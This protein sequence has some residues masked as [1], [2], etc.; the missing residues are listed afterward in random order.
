MKKV[1]LPEKR[2]GTGGNGEPKAGEQIFVR[3]GTVTLVLPEVFDE[4]EKTISTST[5]K[6][7]RRFSVWYLGVC[8]CHRARLAQR[9][10]RVEKACLQ[11]ATANDDPL[12]L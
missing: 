7:M 6:D 4:T 8:G 9:P 11:S 1:S 10:V 2:R 3:C 5:L 12:H